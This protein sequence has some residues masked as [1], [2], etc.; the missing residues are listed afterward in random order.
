MSKIEKLTG[1][2]LKD[3]R[4][5]ALALLAVPWESISGDVQS[6]SGESFTPGDG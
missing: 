1:L 4:D 6:A 5:R 2:S 3:Q